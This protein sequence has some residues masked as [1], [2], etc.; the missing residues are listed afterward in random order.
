LV[1]ALDL[2]CAAAVDGG[3]HFGLTTLLLFEN[4]VGFVLCLGHLTV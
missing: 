3:F 1:L 4:A 2:K